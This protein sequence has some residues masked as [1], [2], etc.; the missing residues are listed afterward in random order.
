MCHSLVNAW[1][2]V[3]YFFVMSP[4][5]EYYLKVTYLEGTN[6]ANESKIAN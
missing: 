3:V 5:V 1:C 6:L 4:A 2:S